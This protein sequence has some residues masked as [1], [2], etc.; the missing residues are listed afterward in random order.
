LGIT[1]IYIA[2]S[3]AFGAVSVTIFAMAK[4]PPRSRFG[5]GNK[6]PAGLF[7]TRGEFA[8]GLPIELIAAWTASDQTPEAAQRLL[9]PFRV[10]GTAVV[11][12]SAGLTRLSL[13]REP[14]EVM[15][16]IN[17]P[18]ELV[19]EFGTAIGGMGIGLWTA[20]NT[21]MFYPETI[22]CDEIASMLLAVQDR[23]RRDCEVQIGIGAHFDRFYLLGS[24][25]YG[26]AA[27]DVEGLAEDGTAA[28]EIVLTTAL[29]ERVRSSRRPGIQ[30]SAVA[31]SEI[32]CKSNEGYRL[33]EG[34][35]ASLTQGGNR[36]Y[37]L[38]FSVDF[39]EILTE[40]YQHGS[41][42][43]LRREVNERFA[44]TGTVLIVDRESVEAEVPE[45][46]LLDDMAL[47][48]IARTSGAH[49]L[50]S[51]AGIEVKT[52]GLL[53]IYTFATANDA[54]EFAVQLRQ[55]LQTHGIR[56]RSGISS[57]ALLLFDLEGGGREISGV[58]VNLA[59]KVAQDH[60]EFG[61][62]YVVEDVP[63]QREPAPGLQR[64]SFEIGG[65]EIPAWVA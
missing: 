19:H 26:T 33:L 15:A 12:D 52:A 2:I 10:T 22:A 57:G 34:P 5:A 29:W 31:R 18:K 46:A 28:G 39:Y 25:L 32:A 43:E 40:F 20:D 65:T 56:T 45:T 6:L 55:M 11:S 60:G 38:P 63:G 13:Q 9:D 8:R 35:R 59:S 21:E 3:A 61:R 53:S 51:I 44:R 7:D 30:F 42:D 64:L 1:A 14:L 58:P 24:T 16:L 50:E 17:R 54:W 48:A 36:R 47:S 41:L 4:N 27:N 62:I 49:L 23:I 37:P